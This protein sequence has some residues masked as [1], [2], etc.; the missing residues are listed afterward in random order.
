MQAAGGTCHGRTD[1][2]DRTAQITA[3]LREVV[4]EL[5]KGKIAAA[6][7]DVTVPLLDFGYVDSL[8]LVVLI[9]RIQVRW[10]VEIPE[11]DL[12]GRLSTLDALGGFIA[13]RARAERGA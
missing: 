11:I 6:T 7:V 13:T 8:S 5:S 2:M 9:E 12:V 3:E 10:G 4:A 1:V